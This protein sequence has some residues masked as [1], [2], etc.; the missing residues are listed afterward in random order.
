MSLYIHTSIT[1]AHKPCHDTFFK[2]S[3][4]GLQDEIRQKSVDMGHFVHSGLTD[5]ARL[6]GNKRACALAL[7]VAG[8]LASLNLYAALIIH[9][10]LHLHVACAHYRRVFS[11]EFSSAEGW[12]R[13]HFRWRSLGHLRS[14][15]WLPMQSV[16]DCL[17]VWNMV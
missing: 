12:G 2:A 15:Q 1:A 4:Y 13:V 17:Q 5:L 11:S 7:L 10:L 6:L 9:P 16:A 3:H 14:E 8:V